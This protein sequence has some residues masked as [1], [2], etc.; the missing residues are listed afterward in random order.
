MSQYAITGNNGEILL[1][2]D[3]NYLIY[4][5]YFSAHTHHLLEVSIIK[6]GCGIYEIGK[7][8]YDIETNDVF[9]DRKSVV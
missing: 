3:N 9:I 7:K 5:Y 2:L 6:S 4:P 8:K 1:S